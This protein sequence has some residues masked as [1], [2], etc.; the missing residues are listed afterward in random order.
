MNADDLRALITF[1]EQRV[2]LAGD[3]Q[4]SVAFDLPSEAEMVTSGLHPEAV[5]QLHGAPW[6]DE[7]VA[8]V[9]E[10]PEFCTPGEPAEQVLRFARDVIGEYVRKRMRL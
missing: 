7:M 1:L 8:E 3:N 9:V 6:R 2:H 10:T 5:R 4:T